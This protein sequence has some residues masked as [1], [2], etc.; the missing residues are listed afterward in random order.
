MSTLK[1]ENVTHTKEYQPNYKENFVETFVRNVALY[2]NG[3]RRKKEL[4]F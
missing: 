3:E 1:E 2:D 4:N